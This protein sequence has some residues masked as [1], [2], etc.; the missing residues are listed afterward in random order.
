VC[1]VLKAYL[2]QKLDFI[3]HAVTQGGE[4]RT[5]GLLEQALPLLHV[6]LLKTC[7]IV[8]VCL[9]LCRSQ[10]R[11]VPYPCCSEQV[12]LFRDGGVHVG[13]V[14]RSREGLP[15]TQPSSCNTVD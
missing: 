6:H 2:V 1:A 11:V 3:R 9:G 8:R 4:G 13:G 14:E 7:T 10:G 15:P 12:E 5:H